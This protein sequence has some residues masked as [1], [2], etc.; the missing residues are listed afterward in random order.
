MRKLPS[1]LQASSERLCFAV[2]FANRLRS[3]ILRRAASHDP[4][5][6][7]VLRALVCPMNAVSTWLASFP[8][9]L[10]AAGGADVA[11]AGALVSA[12]HSLARIAV[13]PSSPL[14]LALRGVARQLVPVLYTVAS[15][16]GGKWGLW[17]VCGLLSACDCR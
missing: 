5:L 4:T 10:W 12:L 11:A 17:A 6:L 3:E 15:S 14:A 16:G 1:L 7:L 9:I 13:Q 8:R 2:S